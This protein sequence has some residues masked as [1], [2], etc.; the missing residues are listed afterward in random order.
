M[1]GFSQCE[2]VILEAA[3]KLIIEGEIADCSFRW[4]GIMMRFTW[5]NRSE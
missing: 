2:Q 5:R 1:K 4:K 3:E